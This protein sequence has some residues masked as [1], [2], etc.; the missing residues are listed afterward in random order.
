MKKLTL[1][2]LALLLALSLAACGSAAGSTD[3]KITGSGTEADPYRISTAAQLQQA[4]ELIGQDSAYAGAC[5]TLA[6]DIDLGGKSWAPMGTEAMPFSGCFDGNGHTVRNFKITEDAADI[7]FFGKV[8]GTVR[9]L[10]LAAAQIEATNANAAVGAIAGELWGGTLEDCHTADN[11]TVSG[12][13]HVGGICGNAS[14]KAALRGLT[15]AAQVTAHGNVGNAA[16]IAARAACPVDRCANS[17]TVTSEADAAGIAVSMTAGAAD[18]INQGDITGG[19]HA[20]GIA[21]QF[22][23]GALNHSQNDAGVEMLRCTNSGTVT[24]GRDGAGISVSFRTGKVT[25]CTNTGAISAENNCGGIFAY[26]QISS[27]GGACEVFTVTGCIN[28]GSV[29]GIG[30]GTSYHAG[31]IGGI[32]YGESTQ[33]VFEFCTNSGDIRSLA[34]AGGILGRGDVKDIR[35]AGCSNE[36]FVLGFRFAG[37]ILGRAVPLADGTSVF[38]AENCSNSGSVYADT[39]SA[40]FQENYCGGILGSCDVDLLSGVGFAEAAFPGCENSGKLSGGSSKLVTLCV[41]DL[42]GSW[43]SKAQ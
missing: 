4:A 8:T 28:E 7:G 22:S 36:G 20:G 37:G 38:L 19:G 6:A 15:N 11:V 17:G 3:D 41:H 40:Y 13:Y 31:G 23:D 43:E 35:F 24:A 5:Y 26:F 39:P 25:N 2:I 10:T 21:V 1:I 16:G 14:D 12:S 42:C 32:V 30:D 18:C 33:I 27:F 34:A 9:G 29:T